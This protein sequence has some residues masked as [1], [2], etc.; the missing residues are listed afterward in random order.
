MLKVKLEDGLAPT[1]DYK[2]ISFDRKCTV[3]EA[4]ELIT[5]RANITAVPAQCV[6][7]G[8]GVGAEPWT[9]P[10]GGGGYRCS[11]ALAETLCSL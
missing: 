5:T 8:C 2:M 4:I 9:G 1:V 7:G 3:A 11:C 10:G 6:G